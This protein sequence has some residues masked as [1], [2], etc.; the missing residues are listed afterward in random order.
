[1]PETYNNFISLKPWRIKT[2]GSEK[3]KANLMKFVRFSAQIIL[4]NANVEICRQDQLLL[5]FLRLSVESGI[6]D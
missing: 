1:M 4:R 3:N 2:F 5:E 6:L